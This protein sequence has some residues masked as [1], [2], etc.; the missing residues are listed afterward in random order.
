[1]SW[2]LS[3]KLM[4]AVA[5]VLPDTTGVGEVV[6]LT[7]GSVGV[8]GRVESATI[9]AG[10]L[11]VLDGDSALVL[12]APSV[13]VTVKTWGPTAKLGLTVQDQ[14]PVGPALTVARRLP[15]WNIV[16]VAFTSV[17]PESTGFADEVLLA[18]GAGGLDGDVE[19]GT[20]MIV[21][22][23]TA[24]EFLAASVA[25]IRKAWGPGAKAGFTVQVQ[26]PIALAAT[27]VRR[28][29]SS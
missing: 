13:A 27:V 22:S 10:T 4:V 28:I 20:L 18:V 21:S 1:M 8:V 9:P 24:L 26:A 6:L 5:S 19:S 16:I 25:V 29:P 7:E 3:N 15:P 23:D 12:F 14:A 2:P 11:M 17:I